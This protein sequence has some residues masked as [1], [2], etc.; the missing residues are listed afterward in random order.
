MSK[1][2]L[3]SGPRNISTAL[4]YS[5]GNRH[6]MSIVDE[7]FYGYYLHTHPEIIHPAKNE[8]LAAL[9]LG[10]QEVLDT[11]LH[12]PYP[13]PYAFL[14]NMAHHLDGSDWE[15]TLDLKNLFLVRDPSQLIASFAEVIPNPTMLDIG[16]K[17]EHEIMNYLLQNNKEVIVLDSNVLLQDPP[18]ILKLLCDKLEIPFSEEM[19]AWE[20]GPREADGVWA[21]YWYANVWKSTGF[22]KQKTSS[23]AFPERCRGLLEEAQVYYEGLKAYAIN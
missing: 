17:L 19:L 21:K 15:F 16:L 20:S 4:M 2:H 3:I 8:I 18:R 13:T 11:Y 9:P 5:F 1:I 14:K 22:S 6:D 23:R 12:R 7:P 10:Y